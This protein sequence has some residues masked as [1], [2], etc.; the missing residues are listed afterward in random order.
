[1]ELISTSFKKLKGHY[2]KAVGLMLF[3][4]AFFS[5]LLV[6]GPVTYYLS[7]LF[8]PFILPYFYN[9]FRFVWDI[10]A[11]RTN[12]GYNYFSYTNYMRN[13][14]ARGCF[15]ILLPMIYAAFIYYACLSIF[16]T[17]LLEPLL[18]LFNGPEVYQELNR[19]ASETLK[20]GDLTNL[21]NYIQTHSD[22]FSGTITIVV[23]L[24]FFLSAIFFLSYSNF[25]RFYYVLLQRILPDAD[26]NVVG[27]GARVIGLSL[28]KG[29]KNRYAKEKFSAMAPLWAINFLVYIG[30]VIGFS[31][32][33]T[34]GS[35]FLAS[36][37]SVLFTLLSSFVLVF[38]ASTDILI[39]DKLIPSIYNAIPT[40]KK[41]FFYKTYKDNEYR[42]S[43]RNKEEN[44]FHVESDEEDEK[45][46]EYDATEDKDET[47]HEPQNEDSSYGFIDLSKLESK[48]EKGNDDEKNDKKE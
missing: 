29:E 38:S 47:P 33:K 6:L 12:E 4:L 9:A 7:F 17:V 36:V 24:S 42:H 5:I 41:S 14:G 27:Y 28:M 18:N 48:E 43:D 3:P 8:I 25:P 2:W 44:P 20:N 13:P 35:I 22:A 32:L 30:I 21:L 31:F 46:D 16:A 39:A 40:D 45:K 19:L 11:G 15:G 37:P 26:L 23:N 1:M 34:G 10:T